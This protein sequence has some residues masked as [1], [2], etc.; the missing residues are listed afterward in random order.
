[1]CSR[2]MIWELGVIRYMA[3]IAICHF[4]NPSSHKVVEVKRYRAIRNS[5]VPIKEGLDFYFLGGVNSNI[6]FDFCKNNSH[7]VFGT[8]D[9]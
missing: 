3:E 8:N 4:R 9:V 1:M 7:M 5:L 6:F 2:F